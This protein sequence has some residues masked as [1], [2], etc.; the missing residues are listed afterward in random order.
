MKKKYT[1][2]EFKEMFDDAV[3]QSL[4]KLDADFEKSSKEKGKD[5]QLGSFFFT[6]QNTMAY[7][8]LRHKLFGD[9]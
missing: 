1:M 5:N 2:E 3:K 9:K 4:E 7:G 8:E 6:L